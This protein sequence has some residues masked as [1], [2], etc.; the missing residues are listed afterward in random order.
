MPLSAETTVRVSTEVA[1]NFLDTYYP[2]LGSNRNILSSFYMP[3]TSLPDG[4]SIPSITINGTVISNPVELQ[5]LL[6]ETAPNAYYE[7]QAFDAHVVNPNYA[8]E[9]TTGTLSETGKNMVILVNANGYVK[10]GTEHGSTPRGFSESFILA[11]NKE[12]EKLKNKKANTREWLIMSQTFRIV[13]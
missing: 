7:V 8:A 13:V 12:F 2:A 9:G 11:P 4:G 3:E 5:S 1:Q 10:Y 6:E